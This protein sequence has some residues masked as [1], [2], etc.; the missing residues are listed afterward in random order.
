VETHSELKA[1]MK[2]Q[3]GRDL[4][5]L[6]DV[7]IPKPEEVKQL[8]ETETLEKAFVISPPNSDKLYVTGRVKAEHW[9]TPINRAFTYVT[10]RY[11]Q[12]DKANLNGTFFSSEDLAFGAPSVAYGPVNMLH[13]ETAIVGTISEAHLVEGD[14]KYGTHITTCNVLWKYLFPGITQTVEIASASGE[15][16]QSMETVAE[17][18][19]CLGGCDAEFDYGPWMRNKA[20]GCEHLANGGARRLVRPTFLASGLILGAKRPAWSDA[21]VE[22]R[23]ESA[24][25]ADL[26][27]LYDGNMTKEFAES[28]VAQV[29]TWAA[30]K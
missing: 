13:E 8:I 10:G 17:Q 12:A 6:A 23:R 24:K 11:A 20:S 9:E 3:Y 28:L 19:K 7:R 1:R 26:E 22:V 30:E 16:W 21:D 25:I 15:L 14:A 18:V 5:N 4:F 2:A 29:L 27:H